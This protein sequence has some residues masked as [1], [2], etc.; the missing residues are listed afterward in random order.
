MSTTKTRGYIEEKSQFVIRHSLILSFLWGIGEATFFFIVPDVFLSYLALNI[1]SKK[2]LKANFAAL[3]G[4]CVGGTIIWFIAVFTQVSAIDL[5]DWIPFIDAKTIGEAQ[6]LA[7]NKG[8][9]SIVFAPLS[10][11][12]YKL[13]AFQVSNL[14]VSLPF[15]IFVT[16]IGRAYRF[17]IVSYVSWLGSWIFKRFKYSWPRYALWAYCWICIYA[18]IALKFANVDLLT[19]LNIPR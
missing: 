8:V 19:E 7:Q 5:F 14:G 11:L 18:I 2:L 9:A 12:P 16:F 15:F 13:V 1:E 17:L 6:H 3:A 10:A 4:A